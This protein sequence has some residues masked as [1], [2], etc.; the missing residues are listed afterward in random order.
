MTAAAPAPVT[1][2]VL[3]HHDAMLDVYVSITQDCALAGV[4]PASVLTSN[5]A[6]GF[7][8][9]SVELPDAEQVDA[10]AT[11][12]ACRPDDGL[13]THYMR[14]GSL[15][16][17]GRTVTVNTWAPRPTIGFPIGYRPQVGAA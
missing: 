5:Y 10:I 2:E 6:P 8:H 7:F 4:R 12:W 3:A 15:D 9:V 1:D 16:V 14:H 17:D 11:E 13:A